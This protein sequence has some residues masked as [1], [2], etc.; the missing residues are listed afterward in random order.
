MPQLELNTIVA[1][2]FAIFALYYLLK[3][4]AAPARILLRVL[5]TGAVGAVILFVFNLVG[6]LLQINLGINVI[7][8]LLVGYMGLPG[9]ALLVVVQKLLG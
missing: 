2:I 8:A 9:L 5:L 1:A 3:M 6:G 7:T 4:L